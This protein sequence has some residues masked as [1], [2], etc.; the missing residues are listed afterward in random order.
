MNEEKPSFKFEVGKLN[1]DELR[2][3]IGVIHFLSGFGLGSLASLKDDKEGWEALK[4]HSP[5][6]ANLHPDLEVHLEMGEICHAAFEEW[7]KEI[8]KE[9]SAD[10]S[11]QI[12]LEDFKKKS[13][14]K[15]KFEP[16][17]MEDFGPVGD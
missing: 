13:E 12:N 4:K 17:P 9:A 6:I 3:V 2:E 15:G 1:E 16:T 11:L 7:Y 14:E 5:A 10:T 8:L